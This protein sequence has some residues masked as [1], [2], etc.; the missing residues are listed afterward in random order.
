M[1]KCFV[2]A[3]CTAAAFVPA[4]CAENTSTVIFDD[5]FRTL[6]V[7]IDGDRLA[8]PVLNLD[9]D[10]RLV[11]SFD[12]LSEER[13]YLRYTIR[14]CNADWTPS[15]LVD[16]EVFDGFN[17][18]EVTDYAFSR[19]TTVHYVHYTIVLPNSE[20]RFRLSGNY[21]LQVYDEENPDEILLQQRFMVNENRVGAGGTATSRTDVDFNGSHQQLELQIDTR[22]Y[23]VRDPFND[24]TVVVEQNYDP[25]S[26]RLITHPS[27]RQADRLVYEHIPQLIFPAS[28]EYRRMET[29]S[30]QF[31][32][33]GVD[34]VEYQAP[35]YNHYLNVDRPR[36]SHDYTYD[37]TQH[38][39]FFVREYNSDN[40]DTEADYTVV[41]FTLDQPE[42]PGAK[43]YLEGDFTHRTPDSNSL[44][45][46]NPATGRYERAMLLK[47]GAYNYRYVAVPPRYPIEGDKY[48]T[49]NEYSVAVYYRAPGER[50]DRLLGYSLIFSGR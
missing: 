45:P 22:G 11:V 2:T 6:T 10:D 47:Q 40:S 42:I 29:V 38:G 5:S 4:F 20:F 13:D 3:C 50:Y 37:S 44:V 23:P 32:S 24:L 34:H 49:V 8:P 46:Y 28:N 36:F 26:R 21:L 19:A 43:V 18:A 9:S 33:M 16:S 15:Q 30:V 17:Y 1:V 14:H 31:P 27:R 39:R 7:H 25:G 41:H 48:Q 35:Y 12:R